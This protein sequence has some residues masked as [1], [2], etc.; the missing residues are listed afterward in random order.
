[1]S[2]ISTATVIAISHPFVTLRR[3]TETFRVA[4]DQIRDLVPGDQV[5]VEDSED[6]VPTIVERVARTSVLTR[7]S[8]D[9]MRR[10]G[11]TKPSVVAANVDLGVIVASADRPA[12]HPRFIDRYLL[13]L[14]ME[15]IQPALFI[16][17]ADLRS[18]LADAVALYGSLD[19]PIV[20]VS[21]VTGA[22]LEDLKKILRGKTAVFV[23]Q[24]GVG[25]SSLVGALIPDV[26]IRTQEISAKTGTGRHTTTTS[27]LYEWEPGSAIIDTPGVRTLSIDHVPKDE[28]RFAFREFDA[29]SD[30]CKFRD[31]LHLRE[32]K[33][34]VQEA[35]ASGM[36]AKARYDSYLRM[37]EE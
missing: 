18:R 28:L 36:V 31:C 13:L 15:N 11:A 6:G 29:L 10:G 8:G 25:K 23:G 1:M 24:S 12:F 22:G 33:C 35:V 32:P 7:M 5:V 2:N 19:I 9:A 14:E 17:K 27:G 37:T 30:G 16:T 34:A 3:G 20:E 4:E 26:D 21:T